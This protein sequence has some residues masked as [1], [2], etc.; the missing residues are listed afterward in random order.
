MNLSSEIFVFTNGSESCDYAIE[1]LQKQSVRKNITVIKNRPIADAIDFAC[2]KSKSKYIFKV[3]DDMFLHPI[4]IEFMDREIIRR[5]QPDLFTCNMWQPNDDSVVQCF[6]AY[7]IRTLKSLRLYLTKDGRID[8][9]VL[10][11]I[12]RRVGYSIVKYKNCLVGIHAIRSI[13]E[14]KRYQKV[15]TSNR[16]MGKYK[17]NPK[18]IVKQT[19]SLKDQYEMIELL[20]EKN[21]T[22]YENAK[23][24]GSKIKEN[25]KFWFLSFLNGECDSNANL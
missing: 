17:I 12:K 1:A 18:E 25:Y 10:K 21:I 22:V 20:L 8:A 2:K 4:C 13:D 7:K 24:A 19:M 11:E 5:N 15:W 6:K 14:Q 23:K 9:S 3:D 16:T